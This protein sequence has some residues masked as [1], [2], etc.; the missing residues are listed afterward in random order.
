MRKVYIEDVKKGDY[1]RRKADAKT[2]FVRGEYCRF[3]KKYELS[4]FEAVSY[5]HLT[6]P[7]KA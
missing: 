7:T 4:D 1:V 6:M 2:T 5:T 3:D